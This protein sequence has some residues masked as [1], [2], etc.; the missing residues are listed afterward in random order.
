MILHEETPLF[1]AGHVD[2][3]PTLCVFPYTMNMIVLVQ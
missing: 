3:L 2:D 1:S